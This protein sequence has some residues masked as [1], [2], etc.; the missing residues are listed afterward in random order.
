MCWDGYAEPCGLRLEVGVAGLEGDGDMWSETYSC[1]TDSEAS[2][3]G[4]S[5]E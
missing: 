2:E 4:G 5:R 3:G 1:T